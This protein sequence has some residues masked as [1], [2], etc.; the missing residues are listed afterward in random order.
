VGYP[1]TG[2]QSYPYWS[3]TNDASDTN[4]AWG[5]YLYGYGDGVHL[6]GKTS[7]YSVWPVRGGR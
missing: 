3:S 2:V 5:V 1:F 4:C 6:N 7:G